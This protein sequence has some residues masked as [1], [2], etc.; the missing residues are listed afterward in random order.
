MTDIIVLAVIVLIIAAAVIYIVKR[1]KS[2]VAC[3]GCPNGEMCPHK[4][5]GC[6]KK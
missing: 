2:G 1:K 4:E 6:K 3:I 5:N